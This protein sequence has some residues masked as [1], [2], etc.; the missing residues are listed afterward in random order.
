[1]P[2]NIVLNLSAADFKVLRGCVFTARE[3]LNCI[4]FKNKDIK[5]KLKEIDDLIKKI[6]EG[7]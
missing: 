4:P 3:T 5:N 1:M 7:S 6:E 2:D